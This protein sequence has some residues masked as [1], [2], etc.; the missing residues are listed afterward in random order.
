MY[1]ENAMSCR[2]DESEAVSSRYAPKPALWLGR[3]VT[4]I[5]PVVHALGKATCST[6]NEL[7]A[8]RTRF[9]NPTYAVE[10]SGDE[11]IWHFSNDLQDAVALGLKWVERGCALKQIP[12][13]QD[14]EVV[15]AYVVCGH[16]E[17]LDMEYLLYSHRLWRAADADMNEAATPEIMTR[18]RME[19][20]KVVAQW[21]KQFTMLDFSHPASVTAYLEDWDNDLLP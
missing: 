1:P 18:L 8:C 10:H 5:P 20:F 7:L 21:R 2:N 11:G 4:D 3:I 15:Y 9:G 14:G 13:D 17:D 16:E 12:E 19:F 6:P